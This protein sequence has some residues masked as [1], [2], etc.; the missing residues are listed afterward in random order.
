[1]LLRLKEKDG[2]FVSPAEFI[3]IAEKTGQINAIS[4]FVI[5]QTCYALAENRELDGVRASI[6]LPML[7][8]VDPLFES[9]LN[10]IVDK[11]NIPHDRISFEFTERVIL[12]DLDIA[13]KNMSRLANSGYTFYLDDFGVGYS[14]FNC[15]LRLPLKTVKLDMTLTSTTET[16]T[17]NGSLV[18]ILTDL[19]HG[20]GLQVVAEG[21]ENS[22][23][24]KLLR[25]FGVDGI[26]GYYFAKPMPLT[27]LCEFLIQKGRP[28]G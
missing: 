26:Q 19:F 12:E 21:A 2:T 17:K 20:M 8:L 7:H 9:R 18:R 27:N 16:L 28:A 22:E 24:V 13:E 4:W 23:Q 15:V 1:V 3:P 11:Y 5:E 10:K 6:N 14:N 25:K